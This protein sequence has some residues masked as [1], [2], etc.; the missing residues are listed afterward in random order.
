MSFYIEVLKEQ[1]VHDAES[2]EL[3][4]T[5]Y[6]ENKNAIDFL[7]LS[8]NDN[9]KKQAVYKGLYKQLAKLDESEKTA[10]RKIYSAKKK[11][12]DFV[13]N[14]GGNVIRE[15]FLD[16]VKEA[17]M[18][19][20]AYAAHICFPHF[21]LPDWFDFQETLGKPA[22]VY[23]LGQAFIIWFEQQTDD[24]LKINVEVGPIQQE[25]RY[26]LLSSLETQGVSFRQ[27]AKM[28]G[29]KYTKIYTGVTTLA[30]W[31]SKQEVVKGMFELY[32]DQLL[33]ELFQK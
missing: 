31:S 29:K 19:K 11:T 12:I 4:L 5:V 1:L 10:L 13:F 23:W 24:R 33:A 16:F 18:P 17:N 6:E 9:F 26:L 8:K 30:N 14:I 7:F 20:E 2:V 25:K 32:N 3:A 22:S 27:D 15:A 28:E 21:V